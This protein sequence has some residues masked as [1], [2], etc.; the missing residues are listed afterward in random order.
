LLKAQSYERLGQL[1]DALALYAFVV[2]TF[3]QTPQG[4]QAPVALARLT[5][6]Q[7]TKGEN[8]F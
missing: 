8:A 4:Y 1:G 2:K 7:A 5:P 6:N 3:P